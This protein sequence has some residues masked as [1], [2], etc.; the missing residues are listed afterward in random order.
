MI[1]LEPH[2]NWRTIYTAETDERS[3]FF[4]REYSEIMLEHRIYDTYIH[5]QWDEFGS[6]TLY[7]KILYTN[8]DLESTITEFNR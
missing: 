1:E 5:P 4:G 8:Y 6:L 2:Y 7:M 3:P